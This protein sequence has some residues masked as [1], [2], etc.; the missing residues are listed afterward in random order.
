MQLW[1]EREMDAG[2]PKA[3][4]GWYP[5]PEGGQRYWDGASWLDIPAPP[6]TNAGQSSPAAGGSVA[7][8]GSKR[9]LIAAAVVVGA[10]LVLGTAGGITWKVIHDQQVAAAEL[11]AA[12]EA[13]AQQAAEEKA[14]RDAKAAAARAEASQREQRADAVAGIEESI[15]V[16]AEGHIAEGL[17]DGPVLEVDCSPVNGGSTDDLT[18][19]TTVFKCFVANVD[20]GDGTYRGY[21]YNATMNWSTGSYTYG[22]GAP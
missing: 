5:T 20:N 17:I 7:S 11:Q 18:E 14:A 9:G 22:F 16:M 4:P 3:A 19:K 2:A 1:G 15:R 12:E 13:E 8:S 21:N 6:S 10:I